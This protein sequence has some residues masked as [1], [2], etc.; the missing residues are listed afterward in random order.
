[1]F[2]YDLFDETQNK[3][4]YILSLTVE[5]LLGRRLHT[6]VFKSGIAKSIHQR[7]ISSKL[8]PQRRL[9]KLEALEKVIHERIDAPRAPRQWWF[10]KGTDLTP[11]YIFEDDVKHFH[12]VYSQCKKY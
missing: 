9:I 3:L 2:R 12:S 5:N 1:M 10:G 11:S 4:D 8:K 6:L 7:Y